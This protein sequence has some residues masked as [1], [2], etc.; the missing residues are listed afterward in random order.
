MT[1]TLEDV[2][3]FIA[4]ADDAEAKTIRVV[5]TALRRG[6]PD[7]VDYV[8]WDKT[9]LVRAVDNGE[10]AAIFPNTTIERAMSSSRV[11]EPTDVGISKRMSKR[12]SK[13]HGGNRHKKRYQP[14]GD[15]I[16]KVWD[17]MVQSTGELSANNLATL[18]GMKDKSVS[19]RLRF[20]HTRKP[21]VIKRKWVVGPDKEDGTAVG[22]YLYWYNRK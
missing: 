3:M 4:L 10:A 20:L 6:D 22:Y 18:L 9:K 7:E 19:D 21:H 15:G 1:I 13:K 12:V 8:P 14:K 17:A 16:K 11:V 5:L 2:I